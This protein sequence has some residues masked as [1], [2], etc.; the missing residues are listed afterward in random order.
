MKLLLSPWS[1][2][3]NVARHLAWYLDY[4]LTGTTRPRA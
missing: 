1:L 4:Q 3:V 2:C